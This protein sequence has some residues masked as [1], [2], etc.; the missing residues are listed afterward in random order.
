MY[1][2]GF[3]PCKESGPDGEA[4]RTEAGTGSAECCLRSGPEP[5]VLH[6]EDVR[7]SLGGLSP[8][9]LANFDCPPIVCKAVLC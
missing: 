5:G 3:V 2:I 4:V 8:S 1:L 6:L 9:H 7:A